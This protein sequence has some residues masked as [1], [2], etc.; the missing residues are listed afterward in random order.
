MEPDLDQ[1]Q[2]LALEMASTPLELTAYERAVVGS[3]RM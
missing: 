3:R 1:S 2:R